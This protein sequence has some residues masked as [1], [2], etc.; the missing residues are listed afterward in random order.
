M[1]M[2]TIL[3]IKTS[4]YAMKDQ[5]LNHVSRRQNETDILVK[6]RKKSLKTEPKLKWKRTSFLAEYTHAKMASNKR[7]QVLKAF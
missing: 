7:Q 5:N 2:D 6:Q 3:E 4:I 1:G